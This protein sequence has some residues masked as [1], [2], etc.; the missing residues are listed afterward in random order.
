VRGLHGC[1]NRI[2]PTPNMSNSSRPSKRRRR[3]ALVED[4]TLRAGDNVHAVIQKAAAE[5]A[6]PYFARVLANGTATAIDIDGVTGAQLSLVATFCRESID[7]PFHFSCG[8]LPS[9]PHRSSKLSTLH[10]PPRRH[11]LCAPTARRSPG[12]Q[13]GRCSTADGAACSSRKSIHCTRN[14]RQ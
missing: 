6:S 8:T 2:C 13:P 11:H 5:A 10:P 14:G 1:D 4:V 3:G 12:A 9:I 7:A